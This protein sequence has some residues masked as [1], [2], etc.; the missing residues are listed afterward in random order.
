MERVN[1]VRRDALRYLIQQLAA[2]KRD[3]ARCLRAIR[4][5][6]QALTAPA[7]PP[8]E[9]PRPAGAPKPEMTPDHRKQR[10]AEIAKLEAGLEHRQ[11]TLLRLRRASA[12]AR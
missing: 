12:A 7:P 9:R 1:I 6:D 5:L 8:A 4:G 11:R 3:N 2:V 10:L